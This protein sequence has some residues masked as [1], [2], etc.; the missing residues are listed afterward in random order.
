MTLF[1]PTAFVPDWARRTLRDSGDEVYWSRRFMVVRIFARHPKALNPATKIPPEDGT[2]PIVLGVVVF[3]VTDETHKRRSAPGTP[4]SLPAKVTGSDCRCHR[5]DH[6]GPILSTFG[7]HFD[8]R[9][10][11]YRRMLTLTQ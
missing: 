6:Q 5:Y 8:N 11:R 1:S 7:R 2:A 10:A 4:A 9:Q 3:A